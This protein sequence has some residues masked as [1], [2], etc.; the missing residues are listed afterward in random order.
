M[1]GISCGA[2]WLPDGKKE[3]YERYQVMGAVGTIFKEIDTDCDGLID[4]VEFIEWM[5]IRGM[6]LPGDEA[7]NLHKMSEDGKVRK[8]DVQRM[9]NESS[10]YTK[11]VRRSF[12]LERE[13]KS[14]KFAFQVLDKN[15]D[16]FL[17]KKELAQSLKSLS[18]TQIDCILT[19]Y[20]IDKDNKLS[21][22]E[23]TNMMNAR[24]LKAYK[25]RKLPKIQV[26]ST[27]AEYP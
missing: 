20:D 19:K 1:A 7:A 8:I 2:V 13:A 5:D 22:T 21:L 6:P 4:P 10:L 11:L 18:E 25:E 17:S 14:T 16:G 12:D 27:S 24:K 9:I 23:F 26:T 3:E 15:K